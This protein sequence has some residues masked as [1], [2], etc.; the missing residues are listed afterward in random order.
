MRWILQKWLERHPKFQKRKIRV[1]LASMK[2]KEGMPTD[3][4]FA[5]VAWSKEAAGYDPA[6]DRDLYEYWLAEK[7]EDS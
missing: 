5:S 1:V 3:L 2:T 6:E 7:R 4:V